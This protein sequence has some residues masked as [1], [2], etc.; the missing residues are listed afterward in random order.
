MPAAVEELLRY[1][2]SIQFTMRTALEDI[3]VGDHVVRAG[4]PVI[5]HLG[6]AN[7]D[8]ARFE[9][10]DRLLVDRADGSHLAFGHGAHYCLGA[11]LARLEGQIAM[12]AIVE[13][14]PALELDGEPTWR[15][16]CALRVPER[17]PL[18]VR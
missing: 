16:R 10:P 7:R 12:R 3:G 2:S 9:H 6:A 8:P 11:A 14:L 4:Q 13:R 17:V 1:E 5:L 15:C 18:R